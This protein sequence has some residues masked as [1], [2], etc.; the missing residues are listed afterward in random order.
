MAE[1]RTRIKRSRALQ[2]LRREI[3]AGQG[4][5]VLDPGEAAAMLGVSEAWLRASDVPR[6]NVAGTKYLKSQCL[7]YVA[8][9]LTHRVIQAG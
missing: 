6:A 4:D 5:A 2:Q 8:C 9:R 7:A 1:T 3:I